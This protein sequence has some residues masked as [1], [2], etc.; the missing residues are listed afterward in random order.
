LQIGLID[1][2][3]SFES[4]SE[5]L[6]FAASVA[7]FGLLLRDSRYKGTASF[8][9]LLQIAQNT[10]G[11]DLKGYRAEFTELVGKAKSLASRQARLN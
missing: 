9:K 5:N 11:N 2:G 4:A 10:R 1:G 6:Q 8:D 7:Q 3:N